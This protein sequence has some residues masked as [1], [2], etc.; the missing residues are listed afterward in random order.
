MRTEA[1]DRAPPGHELSASQGLMNPTIAPPIEE[2]V[3]VRGQGQDLPFAP[4]NLL[5]GQ[6]FIDAAE[7]PPS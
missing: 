1:E 7:L 4:A 3:L 2:G 6:G 5:S